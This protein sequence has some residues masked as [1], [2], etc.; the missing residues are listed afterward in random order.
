MVVQQRK[1]NI[2][3]VNTLSEPAESVSHARMDK[4]SNPMTPGVK[5]KEINGSERLSNKCAKWG[6]EFALGLLTDR[7]KNV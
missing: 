3:S 1:Q 4:H 5:S 6:R 2:H 7:W